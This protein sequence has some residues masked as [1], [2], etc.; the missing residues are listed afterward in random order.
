MSEVLEPDMSNN[1]V[2]LNTIKEV[3][4][5]AA[6]YLLESLAVDQIKS[7]QQKLF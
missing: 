2:I 3:G 4:K 7:S 6:L 5:H 1:P